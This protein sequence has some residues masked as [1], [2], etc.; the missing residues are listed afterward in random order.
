MKR[1]IGSCAVWLLIVTAVPVGWS[2]QNPPNPSTEMKINMQDGD[3]R[4][5]IQ[6]I[7][8]RTGK[9]FVIDPRVKGRVSVISQEVLSPEEAYQ[10][11]LSV[12]Q[13]HGFTA[14]NTGQVT[15]IIPDATA[16]HSGVPVMGK[17]KPEPNDEMVVQVIKPKNISAQKLVSTLRP[18]VPQTG[19][20]V[21]HP[22]SNALIVSDRARNIDQLVKIIQEVDLAGGIDVEFIPLEHASAKDLVNVLKGLVPPIKSGTMLNRGI[23]FVADERSNSILMAGDPVKRKV[24]ASLVRRLDKSERSDGGAEVI[25]LHYQ[26]A[27]DLAETLQ[28]LAGNI[29]KGAKDAKVADREV[30]IEANEATNALVISGPPKIMKTVKET[31]RKLDIRRAQVLVEAVIVELN[32][33]RLDEIGVQW[34]TS[35]GSIGGD[36]LFAGTRHSLSDSKL[37]GFDGYPSKNDKGVISIGSGLS[38]GFYRNGSLRALVQAFDTDSTANILSTPSLV[39]LDNEEAKIHVGENIGILTSTTTSSSTPASNPYQNFER[40]DI[41]ITLKVTPLVNQSE[42]VTLKIEQEISDVI[43][44][45]TGNDQV[46]YSKREI[47]TSVLLDDGSMLVLGGLVKDNLQIAE[48]KVP[49]FGDLPVIGWLF[50]AEKEKKVKTNLMVFLRPTII[51]TREVADKVSKKEYYKVQLQQQAYRKLLKELGKDV[52]VP[53][54][55]KL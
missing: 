30:A 34:G 53:T 23:S 41:G 14:L 24:L 5:F 50:R 11:F 3:I 33:T 32:D 38:L 48:D 17:Q 15:K 39:T 21:A 6:W 42:S 35:G 47:Q 7:A 18:L 26:K 54:L 22:D 40:K 29:Q 19:H 28:K 1:Y 45:T 25:Y 36:G 51:R 37:S 46:T 9:N 31:V 27:K 8:E 44:S 10:V 12:L 20:L 2:A 16:R 43:P 4:S 52:E 55:P 49:F 13:V